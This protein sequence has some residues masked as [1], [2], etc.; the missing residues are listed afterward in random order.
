MLNNI[1]IKTKLTLISCIGLLLL[2]VVVT[3]LSVK[4]STT[5]LLYADY[6]KL[7]TVKVAKT[8]EI[9]NYFHA[10]EGLLISTA[11]LEMTKD[12]FL[13]FKK[14]FYTLKDEV[15]LEGINLNEKLI[16]D[17]EK[18]YL[19]SVNYGV[20][21]AEKR[22]KSSAYLPKDLN[23]RIAQYIFITDNK[24]KLGEKNL[25]IHNPKYDS[26]YMKAHKKYHPSFDKILTQFD[27]YDIF[28]VDLAGNLIY[29]DFKEKDYATNLKE[30]VYFK[31]GIARVYNKALQLEEGKTDF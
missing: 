25:L 1:K 21:K 9:L 11:S 3:I 4:E 10:L 28:M 8:N 16:A 24:E 22:K 12:A 15:K 31:S 18:N 2:G 14:G 26:T 13:S 30:G 17:Y 19:G 7:K 6:N 20:P 23:G 27:L 29:T 5:A